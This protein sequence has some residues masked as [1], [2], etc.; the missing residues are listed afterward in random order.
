V[1]PRRAVEDRPSPD[2]V[3]CATTRQRSRP[4]AVGDD[5]EVLVLRSANLAVKFLLALAA[6][7]AFVAWGAEVGDG[8]W[9]LLVVVVQGAAAVMLWGL[10]AAPK[11]RVR[12]PS[13]RSD[14][15]AVD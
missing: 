14:S 10:F 1:A 7:A 15:A 5:P 12:L 11:S 2:T 6:V 13:P 9:S 4:H 3:A 8:G